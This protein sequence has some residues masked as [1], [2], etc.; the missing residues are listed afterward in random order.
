MDRF[1]LNQGPV[2]FADLVL[3]AV[4]S[5]DGYPDTPAPSEQSRMPN[6][7]SFVNRSMRH[8]NEPLG[9]QKRHPQGYRHH[10]DRSELQ[11][12][13]HRRLHQMVLLSPG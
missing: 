8:W 7:F 10:R 11:L 9:G 4:K 6:Q 13:A 5:N 3:D 2:R 12:S 1:S